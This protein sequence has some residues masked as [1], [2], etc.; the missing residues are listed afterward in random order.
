L[1]DGT[2]TTIPT[3]AGH[4]GIEP[5]AAIVAECDIYIRPIV[6]DLHGYSIDLESK[7]W[8]ACNA[9][10]PVH[11]AADVWGI[12]QANGLRLKQF[13]AINPEIR[14]LILVG[15]SPC[16]DLTTHSPLN[17]L[18][19]VT[20]KRSRHFHIFHVILTIVLSVCPDMRIFCVA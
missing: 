7:P 18:L 10:Y 5:A 13:L 1:F 11:Y 20:G 3:I 6:A 2:G 4:L 8:Q 9:G 12:V 19:G 16:Q 14:H 15:G 17:G